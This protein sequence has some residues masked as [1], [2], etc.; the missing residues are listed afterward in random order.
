MKN[1]RAPRVCRLEQRRLGS[2]AFAAQTATTVAQLTHTIVIISLR[3]MLTSP[4]VWSA[5]DPRRMGRGMQ[6]VCVFILVL[7]LFFRARTTRVTSEWC[8][9]LCQAP[10]LR[11]GCPQLA[12]LLDAGQ[13]C[14]S[15]LGT[16]I[17]AEIV[18]LL[19]YTRQF[20]YERAGT[21]RMLVAVASHCVKLT[22]CIGSYRSELA[23]GSTDWPVLAQAHE[24][25][26]SRRVE[27]IPARWRTSLPSSRTVAF[28]SSPVRVRVCHHSAFLR[29]GPSSAL[30][31]T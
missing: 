5:Q 28:R 1:V 24:H 29:M 14:S 19:V 4:L 22:H 2:I 10:D 6:E 30:P 9:R 27:V 3:R 21:V 13:R 8:C 12:R 23:D 25:V 31:P 18:F 26:A 16:A 15:K 17:L 20:E 7:D 11:E